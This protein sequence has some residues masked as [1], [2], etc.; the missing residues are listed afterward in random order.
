MVQEKRRR[1]KKDK[2]NFNNGGKGNN[3]EDDEAMNIL[4]AIDEETTD[5]DA[6]LGGGGGA[7]GAAGSDS[8][9]E[10][11]QGGASTAGGD[12][13]EDT[14]LDPS[15]YVVLV[16]DF[17]ATRIMNALFTVSE[18]AS[19]GLA[20][21]ES[22]EKKREPFPH[23]DAIYI[24]EPTELSIEKFAYDFGV[25]SS[26]IS[27][28]TEGRSQKKKNVVEE[29]MN[30]Q[31]LYDNM[32]VFFTR[33]PS[34][35]V[36]RIVDKL[37]GDKQT[38]KRMKV[39]DTAYIDFLAIESEVFNLDIPA[40]L[41]Q[42]FSPNKTYF[43]HCINHTVEGL[44]SLCIQL[45]EFPFIRFHK[46]NEMAKII[47]SELERRLKEYYVIESKS[48]Y[49]GDGKAN[50]QGPEAQATLLLLDRT[51]DPTAPLLHE[52][53]Y[54]AFIHDLFEMESD[55]LSYDDET[56][57]PPEKT[58]DG[59]EDDEDGEK[60]KEQEEEDH[61]KKAV[62][63]DN[64]PL[65][66]Q[67]RHLQINE[68]LGRISQGLGD[69]RDTSASRL[70]N[71]EKMDIEEMGSA[72]RDIPLYKEL[73]RRYTQHLAIAKKAMDRSAE[74]SLLD[75]AQLEQTLATGVNEDAKVVNSS[76]LTTKL[77][78]LLKNPTQGIN[79]SLRLFCLYVIAQKTGM[80]DSDRQSI[81]KS[82]ENM[83]GLLDEGAILNLSHLG[84]SVAESRLK[85]DNR[86]QKRDKKAE[87][88]AKKVAK[89]ARYP[90]SRYTPKIR[91]IVEDLC[92]GTLTVEEY[93]YE[94]PPPEPVVKPQ[95]KSRSS[96]PAAAAS[97]PAMI[98]TAK[99]AP[100]AQKSRLAVQLGTIESKKIS[101]RKH[102]RGGFGAAAAQKGQEKVEKGKKSK[103]RGFI[104]VS[105]DLLKNN[106]QYHHGARII[107]FMLGGMTYSETREMEQLSLLHKKD[108]VIGSTQILRPHQY[109]DA[110]R[111][112]DG[113]NFVDYIWKSIRKENEMGGIG[114]IIPPVNDPRMFKR[115][116]LQRRNS[117]LEDICGG[118]GDFCNC[119]P[120]R[121]RAASTAQMSAQNQDDEGI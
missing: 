98:N 60:Q 24:I 32:F 26:T 93:D 52:F 89:E 71:K 76:A 66:V 14:A 117:F 84:V 114:M 79:E 111:Y 28:V 9:Y 2:K 74:L 82:F 18:L 42:L 34:D 50:R 29:D 65:W 56:G 67:F 3:D 45:N 39:M 10:R 8:F 85:T 113:G 100:K 17:R 109:L 62:L 94:T 119:F 90:L 21:I 25:G 19:L 12:G 118:W 91:N 73:T 40:S 36:Q 72:V 99:S 103:S 4:S 15:D 20:L 96:G 22:L 35:N 33:S 57:L 110:L 64:D 7:S 61:S 78:Q 6:A 77:V 102:G 101:L 54:Q 80:K 38:K 107:V 88:H 121:G 48:W 75:I 5:N 1:L 69:L 115:T 68:V 58:D 23:M 55:V 112:L 16:L 87:E 70:H 59:N 47:S 63:N 37:K 108:I 51:I 83:M 27:I 116:A 46:D 81:M 104:P 106:K 53:T 44:L 97:A 11:G 95:G 105:A 43:D 92:Q 13:V 49:H 86:T 120:K 31:P 30:K 41:V